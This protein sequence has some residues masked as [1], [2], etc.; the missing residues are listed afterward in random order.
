MNSG[1]LC[2]TGTAGLDFI[3]KGGLHSN[4]FY[5]IQGDPGVGKTTLAMKFLF[6]GAKNGE[7]CFYISLSES[8]SELEAIAASHGWSF[9]GIKILELSAIENQIK[10]ESQNT[11]FHPSEIEL[12]QMTKVLLT[13]IEKVN[14]SRVVFDS[15]SEFRNLAQNPLRYRRQMLALKHHFL[16]TNTTVLMLDDRDAGHS[17]LRIE[18]LA[19]GVITM[20][21]WAPSYGSARRRLKVAK[22]RGLNFIEGYHD[23]LI[24][25]GGIE[26]FPRLIAQDTPPLNYKAEH[27]ASGV[28]E[29]DALVGG[30]IDRGT[31]NLLMG[32]AGSGKSTLAAQYAYSA[33]KRGEK[34]LIYIF[35]ET[36][37]NYLARAAAINMDFR[38]FL[39]SGQIRIQHVDPA[40]LTPGELSHQIRV[41]AE[42]D[43]I[44][45]LVMDSI[46]GY[47][48]AMLDEKY[49]TV[50]LHEFLTYLSQRGIVSLLILAQQGV[51]EQVSAP[52]EIT[53]LAD[54]VILFRYFEFQGLI[55][56][57]ISVVKKRSG[58][59]ES[60][61]R[62]YRIQSNGISVGEPL[63]DFRGVLSGIPTYHGQ[64][65]KIL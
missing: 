7:K 24:R 35:E 63:K 10:L 27:V 59:H 51:I 54:T 26:I 48:T 34:V 38:P 56:K 20:E 55:K 61:I 8:K 21:M 53:Y 52:A 4:H 28:G 57:A 41:A 42:N 37:E 25:T 45:M 36:L 23:F 65:E 40:E 3:L 58:Y 29:L 13:E 64:S 62:E 19:H 33:A 30:G 5:L 1:S 14:P 12:N 60:S 32:P 16:T 15:L 44:R 50:Q 9:E 31:S 6:E 22:F 17:D 18:T 47:L 46:N 39:K 43:H 49:L 2:K 11:V